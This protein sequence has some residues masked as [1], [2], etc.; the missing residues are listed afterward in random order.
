MLEKLQSRGNGMNIKRG[1]CYCYNTFW[2]KIPR[3]LSLKLCNCNHQCSDFSG[4]E[5]HYK[6]LRL[7]EAGTNVQFRYI[8][9]LKRKFL[10][11]YK[12]SSEH[13]IRCQ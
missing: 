1:A 6:L 12:C 10:S 11:A 3:E 9:I 4:K 7:S 8:Y 5:P 2:E 13:E